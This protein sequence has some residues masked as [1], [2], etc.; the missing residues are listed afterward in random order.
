[1][2]GYEELRPERPLLLNNRN[3]PYCG[4]VFGASLGSTKEHVIGRRFVPKGSLEAQWNLILN[5]CGSCNNLKAALENDISVITMLPTPVSRDAAI[6]QQ[7]AAEVA[8]RASKT[9]SRRTGKSVANSHEEIEIL[10]QSPGLSASFTFAGQPQINHHRIHHLAE[11]HF[12]AFFY[13]CTYE[14]TTAR[15]GF[16]LG[17]YLHLGAYGRGNWGCVE[18][19]WFAQQ[20]TSWDLRFHGVGADGYFKIY[21]RKCTTSEVWSFAVEWNQSL[22]ILAFGGDRTTIDRLLEGMPERASF[23]TTSADGHSVR[24][25]QEIPLEDGADRLFERSDDPAT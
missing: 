6:E 12:R 17:E 21:I 15:G 24:V 8:R 18:A 4:R 16:L 13:F 11:L 3:C 10:Q 1:M 14:D 22:R 2:N 7:L 5:A 20:V 19:T 23:W 9:G 25:T